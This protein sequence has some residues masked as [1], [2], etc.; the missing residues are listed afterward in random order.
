MGYDGEKMCAHT[1]EKPSNKSPSKSAMNEIVVYPQ[2]RAHTRTQRANETKSKIIK[3][4]YDVNKKRKEKNTR[5]FLTLL[6]NRKAV[7]KK[8]ERKKYY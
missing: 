8:Q 3:S 4:K 1:K 7:V 6:R 5:D 2:P